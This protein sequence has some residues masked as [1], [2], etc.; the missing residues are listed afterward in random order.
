V[1]T[2]LSGLLSILLCGSSLVAVC[3]MIFGWASQ[4]RRPGANPWRSS[5]GAP[6]AKLTPSFSTTTL[7]STRPSVVSGLAI[8]RLGTPI[9]SARLKRP[10][11][12]STLPKTRKTSKMLFG[13][14]PPSRY[15]S[16][17]GCGKRVR[18]VCESYRDARSCIV[19]PRAHCSFRQF[20]EPGR[21]AIQQHDSHEFNRV[22]GAY[23]LCPR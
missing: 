22:A 15:T 7:L 23:S 12:K 5:E 19:A 2:L 3:Q 4:T 20:R 21:A 6:V 11:A 9:P 14:Y 16:R 18:L 13:K 17:V 10:L 1:S 8:T